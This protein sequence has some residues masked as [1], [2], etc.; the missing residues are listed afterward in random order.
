MA[1]IKPSWTRSVVLRAAATLA[2]GASATVDIDL[3]NLGADLS[4]PQIDIII[5][6]SSGV[7]VEIFGSPDDGTT[8]DTTALISYTVAANDR[9]TIALTGAHRQI[10]LTN[11]DGSNA[12]GN[13]AIQHAWRQWTS[14]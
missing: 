5:G 1:T 2:A 3:E 14:V 11:N 4:E 9:R 12:T 10:K 8:D 13:I 7:T 6:A